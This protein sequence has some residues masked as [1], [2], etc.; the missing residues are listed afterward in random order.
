MFISLQLGLNCFCVLKNISL[1]L[2]FL[3]L[4]FC[5]ALAF[6]VISE[7]SLMTVGTLLAYKEPPGCFP[8]FPTVLLF[9]RRKVTEPL[10]SRV[11]VLFLIWCLKCNTCACWDLPCLVSEAITPP[12]LRLIKW[13]WEHKPLRRQSLSPWQGR[14]L[15]PLYFTLLDPEPDQLANDG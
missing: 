4:F 6:W 2:H 7:S 1:S 15:C 5:S 8:T 14:H 11:H 3:F 10:E 12:W 13:P 9:R